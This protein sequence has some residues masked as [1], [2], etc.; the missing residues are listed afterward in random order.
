MRT[1][2]ITKISSTKFLGPFI[3]KTLPWKNHIDQIMS[4]LSSVCYAIK[5]VKAMMS[6]ETLRM[7]HFFY[8]HSIMTYN[9]L[10]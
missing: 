1:K 10:G 3:D 7:I 6:Q 9:I 5:T 4:K 8:V 2:H